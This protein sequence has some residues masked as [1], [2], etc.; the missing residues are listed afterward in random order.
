MS[1]AFQA[2]ASGIEAGAIYG[3]IGVGFSVSYRT[4]GVINLAQGDL[5]A[6]GAYLVYACWSAGMPLILAVIL[7][8]VGVGLFMGIIERVAW[9]PLYRYGVVYPIVSSVGLSVAIQAAIPLIWGPSPLV[10][11]SLVP[12]TPLDFAGVRL[13][14]A[15]VVDFGI[16][17]LLCIGTIYL[18]NRTKIGRGMRTLAQDQE[19]AALFGINTSRLF[20]IAFALAGVLAGLAGGLI[21]PTQGLTPNMG[22]SLGIAGFAAAVVGGLGSAEGAL[23]GGVIIGVV[24]NLAVVY[25]TPSYKDAVS[26]ILLIVVLMLRPRG[27]FGEATANLRRV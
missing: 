14:L 27:I 7:G 22:L 17:L 18:L 12:K 1:V 21:G 24:G 25:V 19:A 13:T 2:I 23:L 26:Y 10:I 16:V 5:V 20:F 3:L 9:R 11:P 8:A 15:E 6:L 4:T